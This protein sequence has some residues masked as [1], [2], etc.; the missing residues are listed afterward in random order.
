MKTPSYNFGK[1]KWRGAL[2]NPLCSGCRYTNTEICASEEY[3]VK[4]DPC[5][6]VNCLIKVMCHKKCEARQ[7]YFGDHHWKEWKLYGSGKME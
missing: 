2:D 7:N 1:K 5:P 3:N 6:C 4:K